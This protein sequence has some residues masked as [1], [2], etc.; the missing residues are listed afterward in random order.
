MKARLIVFFRKDN[1][2]LFIT[3]CFLIQRYYRSINKPSL[4]RLY[5]RI[6]I[7]KL[8]FICRFQTSCTEA[9]AMGS[10]G[11]FPALLIRFSPLRIC[12]HRWKKQKRTPESGGSFDQEN[13]VSIKS[14][15]LLR[16]FHRQPQTLESFKS[17]TNLLCEYISS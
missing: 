17:R 1:E 16:S 14:S 15:E 5:Y 2:I 4:K 7:V 13:R 6:I 11:R 10:A 3:E 8:T 12:P 9:A